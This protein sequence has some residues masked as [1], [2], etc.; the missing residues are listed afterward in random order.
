MFVNPKADTLSPDPGSSAVYGDVDME[1]MFY[2]IFRD[3]CIG[4]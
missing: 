3:I 1:E 4:E 2:V